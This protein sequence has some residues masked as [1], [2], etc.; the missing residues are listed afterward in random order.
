MQ[1]DTSTIDPDTS[2]FIYI[3]YAGRRYFKQAMKSEYIIETCR[4]PVTVY[5][6]LKKATSLPAKE[7]AR[8]DKKISRILYPYQEE[9]KT[10]GIK[11][12]VKF[13]QFY[14]R[15]LQSGDFISEQEFD[16]WNFIEPFYITSRILV[17]K[18]KPDSM[19]LITYFDSIRDSN[20]AR[21]NNNPEHNSQPEVFY[22]PW[23]RDYITPYRKP[24][25]KD[26]D[27][28]VTGL[29]KDL[30]K[31]S[32][33]LGAQR[34]RLELYDNPILAAFYAEMYVHYVDSI[35]HI[36]KDSLNIKP[37]ESERFIQEAS[38]IIPVRFKYASNSLLWEG[39]CKGKFD[40]DNT[41]Y[42]V[43]DIGSKLG[44]E[45]SVV[46]LRFHAIALVGNYAYETTG[47]S[48]FDKKD[49][50]KEYDDIFLISSN[51]DSINALVAIYEFS[52]F[53]KGNGEYD[54]AM[55]LVRE[56]LKYFPEDP[57]LLQTMGD[58]FNLLEDYVNAFNCYY[59][60]NQKLPNDLY[61][62]LNLNTTRVRLISTG[63]N[64]LVLAIIKKYK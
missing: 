4:L 53:L 39:I 11:H 26:M 23:D 49:L 32:P 44:M 41:A 33:C 7:K 24:V 5:N 9:M 37:G 61:I 56:G 30:T 8:S 1:T 3:S 57:T 21:I 55:I 14:P 60:A 27:K 48:Y 62:A 25:L 43:Y 31:Y 22:R 54:K 18:A 47:S 6:D 45:V 36:L 59:H 13:K 64:D 34:I 29:M 19:E 10:Y 42:L 50:A 15:G 46:L 17:L 38:S 40:C 16:N 35:Y 52:N 28:F 51:R 2:S 20:L 12:Q 63:K 58:V